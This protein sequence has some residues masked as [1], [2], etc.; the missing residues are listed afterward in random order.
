MSHRDKLDKGKHALGEPNGKLSLH[1]SRYRPDFCACVDAPA[2]LPPER[3][4]GSGGC[5]AGSALHA[6]SV[7][8]PAHHG[9]CRP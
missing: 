8:N 5:R 4:F 2:A 7:G 3:F 1:S 6:K 9:C